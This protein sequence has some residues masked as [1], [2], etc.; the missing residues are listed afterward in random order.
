MSTNE[1]DGDLYADEEQDLP[2]GAQPTK[3]VS[4]ITYLLIAALFI[5]PILALLKPRFSKPP[6]PPAL[7]PANGIQIQTS[8]FE[9]IKKP[10]CT[11]DFCTGS[12]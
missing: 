6:Q 7:T 4:T 3:L 12:L 5:V 2:E 9:A 1:L 8:N 10:V 11:E